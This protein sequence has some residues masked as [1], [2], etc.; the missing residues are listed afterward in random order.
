M[1]GKVI[2][3]CLMGFSNISHPMP[4]SF[5]RSRPNLETNENLSV[6]PGKSSKNTL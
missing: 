3:L 2:E 5:K 4:Y 1:E 6:F